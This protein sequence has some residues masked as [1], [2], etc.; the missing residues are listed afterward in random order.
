[1]NERVARSFFWMAWSRGV[2]QVLSFGSTLVVA[3]LLH[4]ADYGLI[5]LAAISTNMVGLLSEMGLGAAI[6][7]Y[8]DLDD[9]ELNG[10]FWVTLGIAVIGYVTLCLAAS[11]IAAWFETPRLAPVM[12]AIGATLPLSAAR[13]VPDG[14][15]RRRLELD[16]VSKAEIASSVAS[17]PAV[18]GLAWA[19]AGVWALV[20]GVLVL[21]VV[22]TVASFWFVR[23]VP[24]F[25]VAS[26]RFREIMRFSL[27]TLGMRISWAAYDQ[28][29]A[30]VLGKVSGDAALG[31]F[32]M[33]KQ[34]AI[35]PVTKVA[36]VVNQLATPILAGYQEDRSAMRDSFLKGIRLVG[37]LT[38][39]LTVG[40]ALEADDLVLVVLTDKWAPMVPI[41]QLLSLYTLVHS[42]DVFLPS[43]LLA[44]FRAGFLFRWTMALLLV[45]PLAFWAGAATW[46]G[47]GVALGWSVVYPC[48]TFSIA[49]EALRELDLDW[50]TVGEQLTPLIRPA[51]WLVVAVLAVRSG[52]PGVDIG[53]RALRLVAAS[54]AGAAVYALAVSWR[55]GTVG[56]E[57]WTATVEVWRTGSRKAA[58]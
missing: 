4:P 19:G 7:Q 52:I 40:M 44:R 43:V 36:V 46:G 47:T 25:S 57:L 42:L 31:F 11:T 21:A 6:I 32:A 24:G 29:D 18:L 22:Q 28:S 45:M 35:L 8:R 58:V 37:C 26:R 9:N 33:A 54:A 38:L 10:C 48:L 41:L 23:W 14:L 56:G 5:A 3:R 53:T 2:L 1:M 17:I 27:A 34:V 39:P 20:S 50:R 55:P 12:I 51:L 13:V 49:R 15:L 16:K 30:F